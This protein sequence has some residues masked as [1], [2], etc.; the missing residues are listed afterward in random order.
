MKWFIK[1]FQISLDQTNEDSPRAPNLLEM[2]F[3]KSLHFS[4]EVL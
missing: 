1:N 2:T 3:I 4:I